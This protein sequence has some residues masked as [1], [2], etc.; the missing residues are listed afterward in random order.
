MYLYMKVHIIYLL[1]LTLVYLPRCWTHSNKQ[2]AFFE[3][4][5]GYS[6]QQTSYYITTILKVFFNFQRHVASS[7]A[8]SARDKIFR[9][10]GHL[11]FEYDDVMYIWGGFTE[12]IPR[13]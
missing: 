1:L 6:Y 7:M 10:A 3:I 13:V 4:Y 2:D 9:R 8:L 5:L 12:R 11:A